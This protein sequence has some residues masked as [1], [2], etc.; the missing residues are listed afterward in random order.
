M[1]TGKRQAEQVAENDVIL[2]Y[3]R[4]RTELK[5]GRYYSIYNFCREAGCDRE[6]AEELAKWCNRKESAGKTRE[7]GELTVQVTACLGGEAV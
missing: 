3:G 2:R 7:W 6:T 4:Y 5:A 1:G